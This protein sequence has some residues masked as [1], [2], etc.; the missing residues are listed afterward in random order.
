MNRRLK[1]LCI[2]LIFTLAVIIVFL[3]SLCVYSFDCKNIHSS[4][5]MLAATFTAITSSLSVIIA[6][7]NILE[8][9]KQFN[10]NKKSEIFER[11]Y[12][13]LIIDRHLNE[14]KSFFDKCAE[15]V[16][17][18]DLEKEQKKLK[19]EEYDALLA[20]KIFIPF[21]SDFTRLH[22]ELILDIKIINIEL[23]N[24]ISEEFSKF[25]DEFT[26]LFDQKHVDNEKVQLTVKKYYGSIVEKLMKYDMNNNV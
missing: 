4:L 14:I 7:I 18:V 10:D 16:N 2:T 9:R 17:D 22:M 5:E 1:V 11:W 26:Q 8:I 20:E 13:D 19:G 23:S 6:A 24:S 12:K 21:T 15:L 3:F 25:Q